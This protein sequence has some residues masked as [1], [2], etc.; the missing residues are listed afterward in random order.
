MAKQEK[1]KAVGAAPTEEEKKQMA[2]RAFVQKRNAIAEMAI[3]SHIR[4]QGMPDEDEIGAIVDAAL[5]LGDYY[6]QKAF[7]LTPEKK[8]A[9]SC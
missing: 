1:I 2:A 8:D 3:A 4:A 9:E 6:M 7:G 5:A